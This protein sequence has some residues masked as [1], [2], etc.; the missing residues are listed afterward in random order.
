VSD[1]P[2]PPIDRPAEDRI[3]ALDPELAAAI[4]GI[5][6]DA[7]PGL[8]DIAA[9]REFIAGSLAFAP[10]PR[11]AD[12]LERL[13]L[14]VAG[15]GGAPDVPVRCYRPVTMSSEHHP[16]PALVWCHGGGF[17]FGDLAVAD[18]RCAELCEGLRAVIVS[19]DYRLA[20]EH[21]FPAAVED[22]YTVACWAARAGDLG[23]DAARLAVGGSSA[24]AT[25]AAAITLL[26]RDRSGPDLALQVLVQPA[27]DDRC[28]TPSSRS[29]VDPRIFHRQVQLEM[30]DHYLGPADRRGPVPAHAAPARA[31]DLSGLPAAVVTT[32]EHDPLR[33]EG[34]SY[35]ARLRDSGVPTQLI[36]T[37][38]T[39]HGFEELAPDAAV[40]RRM[41]AD[42]VGAVRRML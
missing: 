35:A 21:P 36:E 16:L 4:A 18:A 32:A 8:G 25:L 19:V 2:T 41:T 10:E 39:F 9:M 6:G 34:R 5:P 42:L 3:G 27:T 30:W 26:A 7:T 17:V 24:G 29:V 22:A 11:D 13:D 37:P 31:D 40:S 12:R 15:V 20:P 33:D 28:D 23:I 1:G 38:G 14:E